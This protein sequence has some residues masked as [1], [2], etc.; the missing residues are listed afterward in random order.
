MAPKAI[1]DSYSWRAPEPT[2]RLSEG[3]FGCA[4]L[5]N[6]LA[7]AD[8]RV[9]L[10]TLHLH[11]SDC[12]APDQAHLITPSMSAW[13]EKAATLARPGG[14]N[15]VWWSSCW[16]RGH[17]EVT[18]PHNLTLLGGSSSAYVPSFADCLKGSGVARQIFNPSQG[19]TDTSFGTAFM[20]SL[21]PADTTFVMWE[22][23]INDHLGHRNN[24]RHV[25]NA[26]AGHLD[27][28]RSAAYR[29]QTIEL[30]VHRALHRQPRLRFGFLSLWPENG[31]LQYPKQDKS[32]WPELVEALRPFRHTIDAFAVDG[33]PA[34]EA[35][36]MSKEQIF[37]DRHHPTEEA[38]AA[39]AGLVARQIRARGTRNASAT[40]HCVPHRAP[41]PMAG[42]HEVRLA[43]ALARD[44]ALSIL[45][46]TPSLQPSLV[47]DDPKSVPSAEAHRDQELGKAFKCR[48][49]RFHAA[50][51][52]ACGG[53][54]A[55]L[56]HQI[57]RPFGYIGI[58]A[59]RAAGSWESD[60]VHADFSLS[61]SNEASL[62]V[63]TTQLPPAE[64]PIILSGRQNARKIPYLWWRMGSTL[65][66]N[67]GKNRPR[68][69][70]SSAQVCS[71]EMCA[72]N[73]SA[74]QLLVTGVVYA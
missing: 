63:A 31:G 66:R 50:R 70:C 68:L 28:V 18:P 57:A 56:R 40:S 5:K 34:L 11:M 20:D 26:S 16:Q 64:L 29:R 55:S 30:F 37:R 2:S 46:V 73:T 48:S 8:A 60:A 42:A 62:R 74:S 51:I 45:Y 38:V 71:V 17:G 43:S 33:L 72:R 19:A 54:P 14:S 39:L 22:F 36:G 15:G 53:K 69:R 10:T 23:T 6:Q 12:K 47:W 21:L 61:V 44:E 65:D 49:D 58:A 27:E 32:F 4:A 9:S 35:L 24:N 25:S 67:S 41:K 3:F 52:A 59:L 7:A 1:F 13:F